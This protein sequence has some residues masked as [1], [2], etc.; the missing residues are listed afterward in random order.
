MDISDPDGDAISAV[1][2]TAP[3][4]GVFTSGG[5][6]VLWTGS[7]T[8][9]LTATA[10][11]QTVATLSI[12]TSGNY[13][14][15][16]LAPFDHVGDAGQEGLLELG[17]GV[18]V[19][20]GTQTT[21]VPS[22]LRINVEDDAPPA[23]PAV[24]ESVATLDSNVLIMLDVSGS[25]GT[26]DGVGGDTRLESA[27][28]S[29]NRLLDSYEDL[30]AVQVRLVTFSSSASA[31]GSEWM[32]VDEVRT[33]LASLTADGGTDY[34]AALSAAQTAFTDTGA[35]SGAQNV[36]YFFSDGRPN[37]GDEINPSEEAQWRDFLTANEIN[38]FAVGIGSGIGTDAINPIAYDG[39]GAR[40]TD[41]ELVT[42][43][44][45]LDDLLAGTVLT[46]F[47][48]FLHASGDIGIG[49][50]FGADG[51]S[52]HS[53]VSEGTTYTYDPDTDSITASGGPD[54][55]TFDAATDTLVITNSTGGVLSIDLGRGTYSYNAPGGV[56]SA[57]AG[58]T[59]DYTI[60]DGDG[61]TATSS[62]TIE[63]DR[64]NI[65]IDSG[66]FQGTDGADLLIG[67]P[68][69]QAN[70]VTGSVAAGSTFSTGTDQFAFSF[71]SGLAGVYVTQISI[72]LRAGPD[73][74][75]IFDTRGGGSFGP[76]LG[77][78]TGIDA[79]DITFSP[80]DG[81]PDSPVLTLDFAPG[82]FEIGDEVRFG[83]DTDFLSGDRGSDFASRGVTFTVTLSDGSTTTVTYGSDGA[84]GSVATATIDV[85]TD[86]VTV[87]GQGGDDILVGTDAADV[88][89]G[90]AGRD[91]LHGEGG[92]DIL[93]G[94]AGDD[95]LTGGSG[96]DTFI[97]N[98]GDAG[99]PGIPTTDMVT[100]FSLVEG[101]ALDLRDLLQN[102]EVSG[103]LTAYLN[104]EQDGA[105]TVVHISSNGGFA[106]GYDAAA[107]DQTIVLENVDLN[108]LGANDQQIIDALL[109]GNNLIT[110]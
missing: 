32:T 76:A 39:Q 102:E 90:G 59:I 18:S 58:T 43:F 1:T 99:S 6:N 73:T 89:D 41:A 20:A 100:D 97:W 105:D 78:L 28:D 5:E 55:S 87:D 108:A 27:I 62:L 63:V 33:A 69:T 46:N 7:G 88:L 110:D 66:T 29:I 36:A 83:V 45:Q 103:D 91:Q 53:I 47:S 17:F 44:A 94:G 98:A 51:G 19:T 48:G 93:V 37:S 21:S 42:D 23:I 22:A 79:G 54:R 68:T 70:Q 15:D 81:E 92:D 38:S 49:T 56:A 77:T 13:T 67:R 65:Q 14:F 40:D 26:A 101:D 35:I 96:A 8:G 52:V 64:T 107:E 50:L 109:A 24:T 34:D 57:D 104:F 85:P 31:Q 72:D 74:D 106:G 86:G 10:G 61:D 25:M 3:P 95:I 16:L 84:G 2:L 9:T 60:I 75:A 82:S 12:D 4:D 30:G 71:D 80:A 11:G